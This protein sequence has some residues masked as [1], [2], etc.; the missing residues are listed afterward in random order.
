MKAALL[1]PRVTAEPTVNLDRVEQMA[2]D[3]AGSGQWLVCT[4]YGLVWG[5][6]RETALAGSIAMRYRRNQPQW[7]GIAADSAIYRQGTSIED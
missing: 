5:C 3:A 2:A 4:A 6:P 7:H 1:V